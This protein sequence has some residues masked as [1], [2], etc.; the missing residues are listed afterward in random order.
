MAFKKTK[1]SVSN[2]I[3]SVEGDKNDIISNISSKFGSIGS[4]SNSFDQRI[5][6][7][8]SDLLTGATGIR[9]SNIPEMSTEI[10]EAKKKNRESR[11]KSLEG[12]AF[13]AAADGCSITKNAPLRFPTNWATE[14]NQPSNLQNYIH[15]RSLERKNP[16]PNDELYDI[17]LYVPDVIQ[18]DI[19]L[20]Y[21]EGDRGLAEAVLSEG[22][23]D[24]IEDM[25]RMSLNDV[26]PLKI[27]KSKVGQT[28]NPMKFQ[29][30]QGVNFRT[31]SYDFTFY[32]ESS[33]DSVE[34]QKI[35][36]AFKSESLPGRTGANG[37]RHTFPTEWAVRYHGP[38]KDWVDFPMVSACSDVKVNYAV[39]GNQRM[40]DGAPQAV[41]LSLSFTEL[42][43]L[44]R[45]RYDTRVSAFRNAG[46]SLREGTQERGSH[47]D[48]QTGGQKT[49]TEDSQKLAA[50]QKS[51][52]T[53][54][55]KTYVAAVEVPAQK[56]LSATGLLQA[57]KDAKPAVVE[58][59][60]T[61]SSRR[62]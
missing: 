53:S 1:T 41:G 8:I 13:T 27:L 33:A 9:T 42:V 38:M 17:F 19:S 23:R 62:Y 59:P 61:G 24:T 54:T 22:K 26:G 29:L 40:N 14:N 32:P 36:Y 4:L 12:R 5:S 18:D 52:S 39:N 57:M 28:I 49:V 21:E 50:F 30:F 48:I 25:L 56:K 43:T 7:G 10:L 45:D 6:D 34:I 37:R 44:D 15:F 31:F 20:S 2:Y 60:F 58:E 16:T 35:L 47:D 55:D 51:S 46:N 11:A 3:G